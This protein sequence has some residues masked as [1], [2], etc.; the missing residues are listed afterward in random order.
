VKFSSYPTNKKSIFGAIG[1]LIL[2]LVTYFSYLNGINGRN[3]FIFLP[4][5][6]SGQEDIQVLY[7]GEVTIQLDQ[8]IIDYGGNLA[9]LSL[10]VLDGDPDVYTVNGNTITATIDYQTNWPAQ[11][12]EITID[13]Q[14]SDGTDTEDF[15]LTVLVIPPILPLSYNEN[16]CQGTISL[17]A[18]AYKPDQFYEESFPFVFK[19]IDSGGIVLSEVEVDNAA[20][21]QTSAS[22]TF[23]IQGEVLDR[24]ENYI[25]TVEDNLGRTYSRNSG[26]LGEA[27]SLDFELNFSGMVCADDQSGV[28][29]FIVFNAALPLDNFLITDEEG[30]EVPTQLD[31]IDESGGFIVVQATNLGAG[32]Y[33][34]EIADQFTCTGDEEFEIIIPGPILPEPEIGNVSCSNES[35]GFIRLLIEGG[36]SQPFEGNPRENWAQY[37]VEWFSE[38]GTS[39]GAGE[40][41]FVQENGAIIEMEALISGLPPGNYYAEIRDKGRLFEV[42]DTDPLECLVITPIFTIEGPEPLVLNSDFQPVSCFG[43]GNGRITINPEGGTPGLTISW[44]KGNFLDPQMPDETDSNLEVLNPGPEDNAFQRINLVEGNYAVLVRDANG[45]FLAENFTIIEPEPLSVMEL[46]EERVNIRCFGEETGSITVQLDQSTTGPYLLQIHSMGE[47]PGS[48]MEVSQEM[49]EPFIFSNL[50]AGNYQVLVTDAYGCIDNINNIEITEPDEGLTIEA[51]FLSDYNGFQVSCS[52]ASDGSITLE[53]IGGVGE[54]IYSWTGPGGFQADTKDIGNLAAGEY[55]L[56]ITDENACNATTG[57]V[58]LSAP[59]PL[60]LN[61]EISNFNGF[62]ISCNGSADGFIVPGPSGGAGSYSF[63]WT[64]PDGFASDAAT[65]ENLGPGN[66]DLILTDENG[67]LIESS[68]TIAEPELLKIA[69]DTDLRLPVV[70]FGE[71]TGSITLNI[72]QASVG[73]FQLEL[74]LMNNTEAEILMAGFDGENQTFADLPSGNYWLRVTDDNGCVE[75]I[76]GILIDQPETGLEMVNLNISDYNGFN[77]SC[78]AANDGFIEYEISGGQGDLNFSWEGPNGF[79]AASQNLFNIGAG[80]YNLTISDETGCTLTREFLMVQPDELV[81][82]RE[83][84]SDFNGYQIQCNGGNEGYINLEISGGTGSRDISWTGPNG[85]SSSQTVLENLEAGTYQL[86]VTDDNGCEIVKTFQMDEPDGMQLLEIPEE[87]QNVEC[88]GQETGSFGVAISSTSTGPY[89]YYMQRENEALGS[90]FQSEETNDTTRVFTGLAAG[91]YEVTVVDLNGCLITM[92]DFVIDQ[93]ETGIQIDNIEVSAFNGFNI[94]CFGAGDGRIDVMVSGGSGNFVYK[95]TGPNGFEAG[96]PSI[97][98]L[99]PGIYKLTIYDEN[100]CSLE[101][102]DLEILEPAPLNLNADQELYN[103]LGISCFGNND[104]GISIDPEGGSGIYVI[105]WSGPQGFSSGEASIQNLIPGLYQVTVEDENGCQIT[106]EFE[107]IEPELLEVFLE[108]RIDVLCFGESTGSIELEVRGGTGGNYI[109]EWLRNGEPIEEN[110]QNLM[111]IPS[112]I[113]GVTIYDENGCSTQLSGI[114]IEQPEAPLEVELTNT[115]ISCYN[116]NDADMSIEITGGVAPYQVIW[117]IGST[118]RSFTGIGAGFYQVTVTDAHGCSVVKETTIE[119]PSIFDID[120][121]VEQISCYGANDG[122]IDL[123]LVG[124]EP[125]VSAQW[126]H[127]PEQ[128]ILFNLTAGAYGVTITD[129][130]GCSIRREF[131]IIEPDLLVVVEQIQDALSCEDGQSGFINLTVSGGTPPYIYDWS[132][133]ETTAGITNLT[134]GTYSVNISDQSGCFVSQIFRVNRPAPLQVSRAASLEV[135]CDP[136]EIVNVFDLHI[137]GGV[138]PYDIQ[139]SNGEVQQNGYRMITSEPGTYF[140]TIVDGYGCQYT[141]SFEVDNHRVLLDV[142]YESASYAQFQ[143]NLANFDVQFINNS[144]GNFRKYHWDFGDGNESTLKAPVHRYLSEGTYVITLVA[145][146]E[147]DCQTTTQLEIQI[148]DYFLEIPNIFSPNG[149]GINDFFFPKFLHLNS[150]A[151]TIMNKW[152]EIVFH[153]EDLESKGWDGFYRG[154]AAIPGNYVYKLTYTSSDGRTGSKNGVF[155]LIK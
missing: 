6:I 26:P 63:E 45:C 128:S 5:V 65:L 43:D 21:F 112:G 74:G 52:G 83:E 17:T 113:Y 135:Q 125:P 33:T 3:D 14:V 15:E 99:L 62:Q 24:Q 1:S 102:D 61:E 122:S 153:T 88:F 93:P 57:S 144:S 66:Y 10:S 8:L 86:L 148:W 35:D 96:E 111:D 44:Y 142:S 104:G 20:A 72:E 70:C 48:T 22:V 55:Q 87:K 118:Q 89:T 16:S 42:Q 41:D 85:F 4:I 23:G 119:E 152:G 124:G 140:L 151:F 141:E 136:R 126:D 150:L 154:K 100:G 11:G 84:V 50:P 29:E 19:L 46:E 49:D 131:N 37:V 12:Q 149:D 51:I 34:L 82:I 130:N 145:T 71:S 31:V 137:D 95:W 7:K 107:V 143:A 32:K 90:L 81:L 98:S 18:S 134:N 53:V 105:S 56:T 97:F 13:I 60:A 28:V 77:I 101:T 80:Q 91:V 120:P 67:C 73:P 68:Y 59:E 39:L 132:N 147:Y 108:N 9:D 116:A 78:S 133:G 38:D 69:E 114:E 2:L 115:G 129:A 155:M 109:M 79:M 30:N 117:N 64:G 47:T 75:T 110:T 92:G 146:D 25:I 138:A 94:S 76:E 27:Y 139:W 106:E 54:L 36:W 58:Q 123:N 103:G 40:R 121:V 127:G